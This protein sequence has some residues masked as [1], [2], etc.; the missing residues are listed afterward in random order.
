[1]HE[2]PAR[3]IVGTNC[4]N[5]RQL[6]KELYAPFCRNHDR[7]IFMDSRSAEMAKYAS[8]CFLATKI[9]FMNEMA[10]IAE[11]AGADIEAV[12]QAMG[13]DPRIGYHYIYPGIGYG[14]S[15]FPKDVKALAQI[16]REQGGHPH[17]LDA[18]DSR[19]QQQIR[20]FFQKIADHFDSR[21]QGRVLAIWGLAFKPGT[22][23]MRESPAGYLIDWLLNAGARIQVHDPQALD[24]CHRIFG[25]RNG[26]LSSVQK[27]DVLEGADALIV[28]SEWSEYRSP[29][30]AMVKAR[31]SSPV[32]FDGRNLWHPADMG[33][34]DF[35]YYS[36]GRRVSTP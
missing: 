23:D 12:R 30:F 34:R 13:A 4:E 29:D 18:V 20:D 28:C 33:D 15:C 3:I 10:G 22:S 17:V 35:L 16:A 9:S 27:E 26:L 1:M 11:R 14:G 19:N 8:N 6:L 25:S 24:E 32:V 7:L 36:V 31:L 21:L 5:S 2:T